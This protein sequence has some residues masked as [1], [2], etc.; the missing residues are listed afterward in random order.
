MIPAAVIAFR[1][2]LEAFL[3]IG[4][5]LGI[6]RKLKLKKELEIGTAAAIGV[7]LSLLLA[8]GTYLFGDQAKAI[9]TEEN[10]EILESFLLI[11][12]GLF[13]SYVVF[14]LHTVIRRNRGTTLL[15]AHQKLQKNA[16]DISLFFTI[17]FLVLREGFEI[18]LFTASISL[19]SDFIQN[20]AGLLAG[21][22]VAGIFGMGTLF[23]YSRFSI[24]KVFKAT[25]YMI[26]LLGASLTQHGIS[27]LLEIYFNI[28][29]DDILTFPLG[30]LPDKHSLFGHLLQSFTGVD[31][32]F[33]VPRLAIMVVYIGIIYVVFIKQKEIKSEE[34]KV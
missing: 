29:L 9:L 10:A 27:E 32:E 1:E 6:S 30:F 13:I 23:A 12:S 25:E 17:V 16:F 31:Q 8:T 22:A 11:F 26:I 21:F 18:A 34:L 7:V 20:F 24:A 2:F 28:H 5:F 3:I 19:F 15:Q 14:S 4:V 33:S